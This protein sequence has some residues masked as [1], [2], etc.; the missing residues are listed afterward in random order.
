MQMPKPPQVVSAGV[1]R[2]TLEAAGIALSCLVAE[3]PDR[4][5]R[6][7][8]VALHGGGMTAGYFDGQAHPD[9]S[10][11]T[12]GARLGFTVLAVDRPGYG[13][14]AG[15]LPGGQTLAEQTEVL[16][17]ALECFAARHATG[18]GFFLLAHSFGGKLALMTAARATGLLGVDVSGCGHRYDVEP[19]ELLQSGRG[20][21]RGRNWGPLWL[22]PPDTFRSIA[23]LIA[24]MPV[25]EAE[26]LA[27]WP[28]MFEELAPRVRIPVR[29]TFAEHE[30]WWLHGERD[31]AEI[32]ARL[33]AAPVV[34]VE[35]QPEAGH[36][37]SL[38]WAARSYHLRAL[39]FFEEC[40]ADGRRSRA[41]TPSVTV[42]QM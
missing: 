18:A 25:R 29:L 17:A 9:L 14:S 24:P 8:V 31:I 2:L 37:I 20:A 22:Y 10:L 19:A 23:S 35:R 5:P 4:E 42:S 6:A 1:R 11:L 21:H 36:N 38:G 26:E 40:L 7:T 12:L 27:R 30:A 34:R 32:T 33:A 39:A 41:E 16:Q 15:H 13:L 28:G 3:V